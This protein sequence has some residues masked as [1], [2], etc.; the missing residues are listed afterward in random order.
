[1]RIHAF[2]SDGHEVDLPYFMQSIYLPIPKQIVFTKETELS[3]PTYTAFNTVR[4]DFV[5]FD[6]ITNR[7]FYRKQNDVADV[8]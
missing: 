2:L 5:L 7:Y 1:M 6:P 3:D 8:L 4:Y